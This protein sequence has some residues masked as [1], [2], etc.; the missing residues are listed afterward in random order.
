[1]VIIAILKTNPHAKELGG[2]LFYGIV[3]ID[4]DAQ[5]SCVLLFFSLPAN[6]SISYNILPK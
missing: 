6:R 1:L 3:E 5:R 2:G 4:K